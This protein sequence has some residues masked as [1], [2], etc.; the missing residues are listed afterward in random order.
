MVYGNS[1]WKWVCWLSCNTYILMTIQL[2]N[3]R[4]YEKWRSLIDSSN[5]PPSGGRTPSQPGGQCWVFQPP[6]PFSYLHWSLHKSEIKILFLA[7]TYKWDGRMDRECEETEVVQSR[8]RCAGRVMFNLSMKHI[9]I[10]YNYDTS[11]IS[12]MTSYV[13]IWLVYLW[14][15]TLNQLTSNK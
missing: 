14:I 9:S 7:N 3:D 15:N 5:L 10:H 2:Q 12:C 13:L 1:K 11:Y 8:L 6:P 4:P